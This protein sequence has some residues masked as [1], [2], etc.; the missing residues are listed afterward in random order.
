MATCVAT[1]RAGRYAAIASVVRNKSTSAPSAST[2]SAMTWPGSADSSA[3]VSRSA[4]ARCRCCRR[5]PRGRRRLPPS[6]RRAGPRCR[7]RLACMPV[8]IRRSTWSGESSAAFSAAFHACSTSGAYFTSPKRSSHA[9]ERREP[10]APALDELLGGRCAP[11]ILGDDRAVGVGA[12]EDRGRAVAALRLVGARREAAAHVGRDREDAAV[13]VERGA[14]RADA[15]AQRAAE[16]ERAH[17][18]CR[19]GARRGSPTRC[20]CR[21]RPGWRSRT[22]TR[23]SRCPR[24]PTG[25][26]GGR[27]RRPAWWCPR[28]RR[29]RLGFP[30]RRPSRTS[31]RSRR[32]RAGGTGRSRRR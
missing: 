17:L 24:A 1:E 14:Q 31:W 8:T 20:S 18:R 16:V 21:G 15:R 6:T 23:R 9:R 28:R 26:P 13:A 12:D 3:L 10:G 27:P 22:T 7:A 30:C 19:A 32:G 29:R 5:S 25:G 2:T 4:G 11:E